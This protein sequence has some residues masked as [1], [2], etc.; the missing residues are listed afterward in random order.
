MLNQEIFIDSYR[1]LNHNTKS[2][3]FRTKDCKKRSRL[4]YGLISPSLAIHLKNV[5]HI[6]HHYEN[7]DHSTISL[8][9]DITNS[10]KGK[11]I[12]RCPPNIH[13]NIDYQILIKNTI[14]KNNFLLSRKNPKD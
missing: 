13:N 2:Y 11:G 12:F 1:H 7:T 5:Q 9:I 14:K 4:D 6:A 10:E 8:D 3:T